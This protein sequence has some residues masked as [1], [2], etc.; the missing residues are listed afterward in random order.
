MSFEW[1]VRFSVCTSHFGE[2]I[3]AVAPK[4]E[5]L[6]SHEQATSHFGA[7][8]PACFTPDKFFVVANA[9]LLAVPWDADDYKEGRRVA[10]QSIAAVQRGH[11]VRRSRGGRSLYSR[12][13][14][15]EQPVV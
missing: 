10:V 4:R 1:S 7:C 6:R 3:C 8:A 14:S 15:L 9:R 12:F 13:L 2:R 11:H 5:G